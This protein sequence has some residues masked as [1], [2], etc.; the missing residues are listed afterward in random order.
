MAQAWHMRMPEYVIS[1]AN[2][3]SISNKIKVLYLQIGKKV[4]YL[5]PANYAVTYKVF[6]NN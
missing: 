2:L 6:I 5:Q 3:V 4:V 1:K